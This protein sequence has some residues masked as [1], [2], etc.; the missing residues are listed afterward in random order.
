MLLGNMNCANAH[1]F[2]ILIALGKVMVRKYKN[3][4]VLT[5]PSSAEP[6]S[7]NTMREEED[8]GQFYKKC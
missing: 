3:Y 2:E 7:R 8:K 6:C 1:I 4:N 5:G